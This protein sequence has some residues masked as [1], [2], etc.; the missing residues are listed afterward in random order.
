MIIREYPR[1]QCRLADV[2]SGDDEY[3]IPALAKICGLIKPGTESIFCSFHGRQRRV[4]RFSLAMQSSENRQPLQLRPD[5][6]Y[7]ITG[8]LGGVGL[9]VARWLVERGAK[10]LALVG[11]SSPSASAEKR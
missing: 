11:R 6:A 3:T 5:G 10:H 7:L 4:A 2:D 9:K 8:G 1:L